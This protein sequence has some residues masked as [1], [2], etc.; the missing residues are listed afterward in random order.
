MIS[1]MAVDQA[2]VIPINSNAVM[3]N[4]KV[5]PYSLV[6]ELIFDKEG[7]P[8]FHVLAM[9]RKREAGSGYLCT[10]SAQILLICHHLK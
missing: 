6:F 5:G 7:N 2:N 8:T 3:P 1:K 9:G 10:F 4:G